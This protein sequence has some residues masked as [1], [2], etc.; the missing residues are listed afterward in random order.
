MKETLDEE[1]IRA[2]A[3]E[4]SIALVDD[5][6][7]R[8][9]NARYRKQDKATDVLSFTQEGA[10]RH[11][12]LPRLLGDVVISVDTA[13]RQAATQGHALEDE[14]CHLA[15]HGVL[16]LLGYDD[17]TPEGY[18]EMVRKG[19]EIWRRVGCTDAGANRASH[20]DQPDE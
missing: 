9:L 17:V 7:M 18:A 1:G 5:A 13:S 15:I 11:P 8:A 12:G 10:I 4:L 3:V 6:D 20:D 16:H 19:A 2:R 14:L